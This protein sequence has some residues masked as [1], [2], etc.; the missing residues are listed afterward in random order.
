MS[1]SRLQLQN[2]RNLV[3]QD[4]RFD[5]KFNIFWGKNGSG[6]TSI[7]EALYFLGNGKSFRTENRCS[8]IREGE[9]KATLL[10]ELKYIQ[11]QIK[12]GIEFDKSN[13]RSRVDGNDVK[14]RSELFYYLPLIN[15]KPHLQEIFK[16][17]PDVRRRM[18]DWGLFHV[19]HSYFRELGKYRKTLA[20]RNALL[21]SSGDLKQLGVW[22]NELAQSGEFVS[23]QRGSFIKNVNI[24]LNEILNEF[25]FNYD[26]DIAYKK[27]WGE[28]LSLLEALKQRQDSDLKKGYTST[29]PHRS[30]F[31]FSYKGRNIKETFSEGQKKIL[32]VFLF[33]AILDILQKQTTLEVIVLFDDISS[34]LD[35]I[36]LSIALEIFNKH[37]AQV[38]LTNIRQ[39]EQQRLNAYQYR[40][41]HVEQGQ[42]SY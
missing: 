9:Q 42:I 15:L 14:K 13:F 32:T 21:K 19:E 4:L 27:G 8:V 1:I 22:D 35:D 29:G 37:P 23:D 25:E 38:F 17:S 34:E 7:L 41:F 31:I 18:I 36:H 26:I 30:D 11:R 12:L 3:D 20:Q 5:S 40:L 2:F 28:N 24:K 39:P 10:S 6:K 33:S 16:D